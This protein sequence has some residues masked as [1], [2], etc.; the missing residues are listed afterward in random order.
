MIKFFKAMRE[1]AKDRR[2]IRRLNNLFRYYIDCGNEHI[3]DEDCY[4][5]SQYMLLAND[6]L[7]KKLKLLSKSYF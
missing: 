6:T 1:Y 2:E 7:A 3:E 4:T 5:W